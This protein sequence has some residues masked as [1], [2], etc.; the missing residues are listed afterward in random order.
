MPCKT[1]QGHE[2]KVSLYLAIQAMNK[3]AISSRKHTFYR[4]VRSDYF[5]RFLSSVHFWGDFYWMV[6]MLDKK[7]QDICKFRHSRLGARQQISSRDILAS[8]QDEDT[9][10]GTTCWEH[11][12]WTGRRNGAGGRLW[13]SMACEGAREQRLLKP[14]PEEAHGCHEHKSQATLSLP[15]PSNPESLQLGSETPARLSTLA[16]LFPAQPH[17]PGYNI[18]HTFYC[19]SL[20][21]EAMH[22]NLKDVT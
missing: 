13:N 20:F 9:V 18:L 12:R 11:S 14:K 6:Y 3:M 8:T 5:L 16:A 10:L 15:L 4:S 19:L 17:S 2:N 22:L 1:K 21:Q 7:K